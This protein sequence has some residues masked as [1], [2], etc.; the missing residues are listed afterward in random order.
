MN[1]K[2]LLGVLAVSLAVVFL[3]PA[4]HADS[5]GITL[6]ETIM[7]GAAGTTITFD[8]SLINL[9]R[10]H[11]FPQRRQLDDLFFILD[12]ERQSLSDQCAA[13]ARR[14]GQ[15]RTVRSLQRANRARNAGWNLQPQHLFHPGRGRWHHVQHHWIGRLHRRRFPRTRAQHNR[16]A[17]RGT[18][19]PRSPP[20]V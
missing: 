6:T 10:Q 18:A 8:A 13:F 5:V 3:S 1:R 7:T 14:R 12:R 16:A 2:R 17:G 4:A 11:G 19:R 9:S 20:P 15:Q